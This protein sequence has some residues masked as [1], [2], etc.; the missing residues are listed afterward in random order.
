MQSVYRER[1]FAVSST[2]SPR[3]SC[4]SLEDKLIA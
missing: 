3:D 2:D 4:V 1:V